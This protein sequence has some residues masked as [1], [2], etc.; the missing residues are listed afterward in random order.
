MQLFFKVILVGIFSINYFSVGAQKTDT[1]KYSDA[2]SL[3][4]VGKIAATQNIYHR[5]DTSL[6]PGFPAAVKKLLTNSAGL[7]ISFKT[8]STVIA[9]KWCVSKARPAS[10]LNPIADKGLDIYIKRNGKWQFAGV[11]RPTAECNRS[12]MVENM[13]NEEKECLVYLPLYDELISLEIGITPGA[14]I[15]LLSSPFTKRVLIYGS[16]IVQGA[17]ASRPGLAYPA[18][19]SRATGLNFLNMG[20]SASAKME[21]EVADAVA[22]TPAEAYILDCVPNSSPEQIKERTVYLVEQIRKTQSTAPI[23]IMQSII[24]EHGYFNKKVGERVK[25]QN[26]EIKKQFEVLQKKGIKNLYFIPADNLTG[27]DHEAS[28][29]GIHP[30]DLG[31][32]RMVQEMQPV[33]IKIFQAHGLLNKNEQVIDATY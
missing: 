12:I 10:N 15:T 2:S 31:F 4:M 3:T 20:L 21:K 30:T 25:Q 19:L 7:A 23:I 6:Y 28:A 13:D 22:A 16:S 24:R 18:Q 5:L 29:D 17:S 1:L 26:I 27:H 8:N 33:L 14:S 9:A 32:Y 11:G